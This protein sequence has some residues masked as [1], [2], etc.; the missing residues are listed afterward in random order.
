MNEVTGNI[1]LS[2]DKLLVLSIPYNKGWTAY[3]DGKKRDLKRVN[4]TYMGL[5]MEKGVHTIRLKYET[6]GLKQGCF[7]S[8]ATAVIAVF[9]FWGRSRR[10][11]TS[12]NN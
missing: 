6:Y 12:R 8:G 5:L 2:E 7:I 9:I 1:K 10:I 11:K 3:V 4:V